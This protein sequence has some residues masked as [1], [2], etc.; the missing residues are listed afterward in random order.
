[1]DGQRMKR[2]GAKVRIYP[3]NEGTGGNRGTVA[4]LINKLRL[5]KYTAKTP[6]GMHKK[7]GTES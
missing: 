1:M 7:R 3:A 4:I 2:E 6:T 5:T